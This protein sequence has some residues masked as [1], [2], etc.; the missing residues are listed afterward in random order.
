[1]EPLNYDFLGYLKL[2]KRVGEEAKVAGCVVF[3]NNFSLKWD[4]RKMQTAPTT[5]YVKYDS[6]RKNPTVGLENN[7]K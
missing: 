3:W 1:M 2:K 5:V 6:S 4:S 7:R